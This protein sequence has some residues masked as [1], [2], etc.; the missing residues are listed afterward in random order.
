MI[1]VCENDKLG[2]YIRAWVFSTST[3]SPYGCIEAI[4]QTII[5][6]KRSSTIDHILKNLVR[7]TKFNIAFFKAILLN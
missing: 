6:D 1:P 2:L 5:N 7:G 3:I 4:I